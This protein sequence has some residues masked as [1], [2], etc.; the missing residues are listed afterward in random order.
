MLEF[1]RQFFINLFHD[2]LTTKPT[3]LPMNM[4]TPSEKL[5]ET[6]KAALGT[7]IAPDGISELGCAF[8]VNELYK[9]TFGKDI[10]PAPQN[11]STY[12]LYKAMKAG[13]FTRVTVT[14]PPMGY[15][16]ISPSGYGNY[17]H[18][19]ISIAGKNMSPDGTRYLMSNNSATGT[20]EANYTMKSWNDYFATKGGFI[21]AVFRPD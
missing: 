4:P 13:P 6:A 8:S 2:P 1:I 14:D 3:E 7:K 12:W 16:V 11:E 20:W 10:C 19:H 15:I 9:R 5:Y 21:V 17:P 18:G